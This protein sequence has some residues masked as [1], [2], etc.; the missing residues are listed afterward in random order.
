LAGL[1]AVL[2]VGADLCLGQPMWH[3]L[4]QCLVALRLGERIGLCQQIRGA[5]F[6]ILEGW[7]GEGD[8]GGTRGSQVLPARLVSTL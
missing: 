5:L 1:L 3:A 7:G 4:R 2:S 8:P 6:Q